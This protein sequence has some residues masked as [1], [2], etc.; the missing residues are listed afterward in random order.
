MSSL[1]LEVSVADVQRLNDEDARALVRRLCE[2]EVREKG[3]SA[4][5][6]LA[7]GHQNAADEGSDVRVTGLPAGWTPGFIVRRETVFQV[8]A[9]S[10]P[11]SKVEK[12]MRQSGVLRPLIFDLAVAGGAYVIVSTRDNPSERELRRRRTAMADA[13]GSGVA[14]LVCEFYG[15]DRLATWANQYPGVALWLRSKAGRGTTGWL[16]LGSWSAS[17]QPADSQM[18]LDERGRLRPSGA[19]PVT[20]VEGLGLMRAAL[21]PAAAVRLVGLSGHGK[22]RLAQALFDDRVG[23]GALRPELAIYA[24]VGRGAEPSP[25]TVADQLV[26]LGLEAALVVDNCPAELHRALIEIVRRPGSQVRLLTI[27]YDVAEDDFETTAEFRLE[28]ASDALVDALL[29]SRGFDLS[30]PDRRRIAEFAGGNARM[31]L[32][33]AR[34]ATGQ[35]SLASLNDAELLGRL[36]GRAPAPEI[37][38]TAEV[39]ALVVSFDVG[40]LSAEGAEL[41]VLAG[42]AGVSPQAFYGA[43]T[44][45]QGIE[46]VQQRANWRAVLPQALA[47]KLARVALD[48]LHPDLLWRGLVLEAQPRLFTS[49]CHRL[50][51]LHDVAAATAIAGKLLAPGGLLGDLVALDGEGVQRLAHLAPAVPEAALAAFERAWA[52][53]LSGIVAHTRFEDL[54]RLLTHL[55]YDPALFSRAALLL[56]RISIECGQANWVH[57]R[58]AALFHLYLSGTAASPTLRFGLIRAWVEAG[59]L[60]L[61]A[62]A[63]EAALKAGTFTGSHEP[64]FGAHQRDYGWR[65]RTLADQTAWFLDALELLEPL[66]RRDPYEA[67]QILAHQFRQLWSYSPARRRLIEV[68]RALVASV[69]DDRIWFAVRETIGFDTAP[70]MSLD[71]SA[72]EDLERDLRPSATEDL[73]STYVFNPN[74]KFWNEPG[75]GGKRAA[76]AAAGMAKALGVRA[77]ADPDAFA[78]VA[79]QLLQRRQTQADLFGEGYA[80]QVD[81]L[82]GEWMRLTGLVSARDGADPSLLMGFVRGTLARDPLR[83]SQWLDAALNEPAVARHLV[84]LQMAAGLD[85]VGVVRWVQGI[86]AGVIP[87]GSFYM[88]GGAVEGLGPETLGRLLAA[89][90][91]QPAGLPCA[92]ELLSMRLMAFKD[93]SVPE[94]WAALCRNQLAAFRFEVRGETMLDYYLGELALKGLHGSAGEATARQVA[95][96][97]KQAATDHVGDYYPSLVRSLFQRHPRAALDV[98]VEPGEAW[99]QIEDTVCGRS[100]DPDDRPEQQVEGTIAALDYD[101]ARAW[102]AEDPAT[103]TARL[104]LAIPFAE[105]GEGGELA[106]TPLARELLDGPYGV[107]ALQVF[108]PRFFPSFS[109]GEIGDPW[110][111]RRPLLKRLLDHWNPE[112]AEAARGFSKA[113][114]ERIAWAASIRWHDEDQA[115]E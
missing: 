115:F 8:K 54:V 103:H 55:A 87:V 20:L 46:L 40:S 63:L 97:L 17:D 48:R 60:T 35:G 82:D 95:E 9:E 53:D 70:A 47:A 29:K 27:E 106:W 102:V 114:E 76:E 34:S 67:R 39:S 13:I 32:A 5:C 91:E 104:A 96:T 66:G 111:R 24:D 19:Q 11:A 99:Q 81:D 33:L 110:I 101:V 79:E 98:L 38:P 78:N 23:E 75:D 1:F 21:R 6:V 52:S 22:T 74:H 109:W 51:L 15:A 57:E 68:S 45:L 85:D 108:Y 59:E 105:H 18:I 71:Q 50:G 77:A 30:D 64:E 56:G 41:P 2:A 90:G 26:A 72:L 61:A 88:A 14:P 25:R 12:E 89:I 86:A 69:R 92:I 80:S 58:F 28:R 3:A 94:P 49:F 112:L 83:V 31:A 107:S 10:M 100:S 42:L 84:A 93:E 62:R 43:V 65:P 4:S 73:I 44:V 16:G 113:L 7:G 37:R 36:F